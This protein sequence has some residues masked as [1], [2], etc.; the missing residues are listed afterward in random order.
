[1]WGGCV[2]GELGIGG[3]RDSGEAIEGLAKNGRALVGTGEVYC[4]WGYG[5]GSGFG[6][7]SESGVLGEAQQYMR[8]YQAHQLL[9]L[10]LSNYSSI[11]GNCTGVSTANQRSLYTFETV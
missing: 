4:S 6:M 7:I 5:Q 10:T 8:S 11:S 9:S 2:D 1:M 3:E